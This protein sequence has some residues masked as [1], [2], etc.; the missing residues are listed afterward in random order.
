[1]LKRSLSICFQVHCEDASKFISK[2]VLKYTPKS[3]MKDP[4]DCTWWLTPSLLDFTLPSKLSR[5]SQ[6]HFQVCGH[7]QFQ[8]LWLIHSLS[9]WPMYPSKLSMC[10]QL[11][12]ESSPSVHA[13]A[14]QS[15]FS[16]PLPIILW[17]ML[18]IA[19]DGI[20]PA[21]FTA[22]IEESFEATLM[23]TSKY[24]LKYAPN[25]TQ[26]P[27]HTLLY[28]PKYTLKRH[29]TFNLT[30]QYAL[31]YTPACPIHRH[32]ELQAPQTWR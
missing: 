10:S 15:T 4:P 7:V 1:M 2:Y 3:A 30:W 18:L 9:S 17:M 31:I 12:S 6:T 5:H 19:L 11:Y 24:S 23:Y 28:T 20:H 8:M 32:A 27:Q 26:Q 14:P 13:G 16:S 25:C 29:D 22:H 21:C